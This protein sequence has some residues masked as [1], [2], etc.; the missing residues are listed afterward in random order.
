MKLGLRYALPAVVL[1]VVLVSPAASAMIVQGHSPIVLLVVDPNGHEI[2]CLATNPTGCTSTSSSDYRDYMP[3]SEGASY[4]F[5]GSPTCET[6]DCPLVTITN[7]TPGTWTVYYYSTLTGSETG[8]TYITVNECSNYPQVWDGYGGTNTVS[9]SWSSTTW[10]STSSIS[11][12]TINIIGSPGDPVWI[13]AGSN[14]KATFLYPLT[15]T[16]G[17]PEFPY[18]M[19]LLI[20]LVLPAL[21]IYT[22]LQRRGR[23]KTRQT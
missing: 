12:C 2:G 16:L 15:G 10:T 9:S 13:G 19:L 17:V 7:P 1:L 14:G 3:G 4:A 22:R 20:A 11:S 8:T 18:G 23:A 5:P 6:T 21:L